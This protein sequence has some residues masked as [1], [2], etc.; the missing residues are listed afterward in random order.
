MRSYLN[1][2]GLKL[3]SQYFGA[4]AGVP[5]T[6]LRTGPTA[7]HRARSETGPSPQVFEKIRLKLCSFWT[8][9]RSLES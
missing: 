9:F 8:W 4:V 3:T 6:T 1:G 7:P 5:S 2:I